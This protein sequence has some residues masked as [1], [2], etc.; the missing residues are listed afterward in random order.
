MFVVFLM[1]TT[2]RESYSTIGSLYRGEGSKAGWWINILLMLPAA[3][4]CFCGMCWMLFDAR[5]LNFDDEE[6]DKKLAT[7]RWFKFSPLLLLVVLLGIKT[8]LTKK[9]LPR[10][11]IDCVLDSIVYL[12]AYFSL[13]VAHDRGFGRLFQ[14]FA[15]LRTK[16]YIDEKG[17]KFHSNI[18]GTTMNILCLGASSWFFFIRSQASEIIKLF[19]EKSEDVYKYAAHSVITCMVLGVMAVM[20]FSCVKITFFLG[21]SRWNYLKFLPVLLAPFCMICAAFLD[22]AVRSYQER[23]QMIGYAVVGVIAYLSLLSPPDTL[24]AVLFQPYIAFVEL[25]QDIPEPITKPHV[26][27]N[28]VEPTKADLAK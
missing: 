5:W 26:K 20:F 23:I 16:T 6:K 24:F 4:V 8:A 1:F 12:C 22:E 10:A 17:Q 14:P 15:V 25:I 19:M 28:A 2:V 13:C 11:I 18:I 7:S 21:R 9:E 3:L 27:T